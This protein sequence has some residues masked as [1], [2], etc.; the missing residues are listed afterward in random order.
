MVQERSFAIK[1]V[2]VNDNIQ[3][4]MHNKNV[5]PQ[6]AIGLLEM[7]KSQILETLAQNR[8]ELFSGTKRD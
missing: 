1:F 4:Q 8:K 6:E 7:A 3:T 2:I 5:P